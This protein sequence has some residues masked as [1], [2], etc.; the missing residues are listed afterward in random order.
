MD[1]LTLE[2]VED[3]EGDGTYKQVM[4]VIEHLKMS[5]PVTSSSYYQIDVFR[6]RISA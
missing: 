3:G 5:S 1:T 4:H 6:D 2:A